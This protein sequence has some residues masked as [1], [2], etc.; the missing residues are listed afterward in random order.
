MNDRSKNI[1][2]CFI[3]I[4]ICLYISEYFLGFYYAKS[5]L[6]F[7]IP[8]H[9]DQKHVTV[10]YQATYRYNNISLRSADYEPAQVYDCV[11]LGDSFFFGQGINDGRSFCGILQQKGYKVLN[12]SEIA[13]N[14][15]DYF[16]KF[17]ILKSHHLNTKKIVVELYM[18]NDFQD[19]T[20]KK[21]DD[22]LSYLYRP[23]FL[24]YGRSDFFKLERVRYLVRSSWGQAKDWIE[25]RYSGSPYSE[26]VDVHDFEIK[27]RFYSDWIEFFSGN[28]MDVMKVLQGYDK[29]PFTDFHMTEDEYIRI[30]QINKDSLNNTLKILNTFA[31]ISGSARVYVMLIPESHYDFG[32]RSAKYNEFLHQ[33]LSG[34][35]PSITVIDLHGL[36]N[37]EMHYLHD[38]HWNEKGHQFVADIIVRQI[39]TPPPNIHS[40]SHSTQSQSLLIRM[41]KE[42]PGW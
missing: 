10:D 37:S 1:L 36:I 21:I 34:L 14:P 11:F 9:V 7:P 24:R 38:G 35:K 41:K 25:S 2:L 8:P 23:E 3:S 30:G 28:N 6:H 26:T 13:T 29:K 40:A 19:I 31:E 32:Y 18:G 39:L 16:H 20:D 22:A 15:I 27:K 4:S 33:V 5:I 12:A 42:R 17:R